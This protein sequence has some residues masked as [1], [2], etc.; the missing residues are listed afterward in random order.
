[1]ARAVGRY[2]LELINAKSQVKKL[3]LTAF[4]ITLRPCL[5]F[6]AHTRS[7]LILVIDKIEI[8]EVAEWLKAHAWKVCI[9]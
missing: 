1:M 9:R 7:G 5:L 3:H 4:L 8:G 6:A 2:C